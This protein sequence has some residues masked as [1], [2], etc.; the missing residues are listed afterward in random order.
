[1]EALEKAKIALRAHLLA[2]KDKVAAEFEQMR[3]IS[4]GKDISN[5]LDAI[6]TAFSFDYLPTPP[7]IVYEYSFD[8]YG[9]EEI[10][11][12]NIGFKTCFLPN[13]G[14][15]VQKK[16]LEVYQGLFFLIILQDDRRKKSCIYV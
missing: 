13:G 7:E 11:Y 10:H 6:S 9:S 14:K 16:T 12:E 2:N 3:K 1:M 4:K 15:H 5:Y 8:E